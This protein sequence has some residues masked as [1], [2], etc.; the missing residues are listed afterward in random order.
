[1]RVIVQAAGLRIVDEYLSVERQ[2]LSNW[3]W[4]DEFS[5]ETIEKVREFIG[6]HG[7]ETGMEFEPEGDDWSFTRRRLMILAQRA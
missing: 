6:K 4:P 5:E 3:M 7:Q 2:T 1:M